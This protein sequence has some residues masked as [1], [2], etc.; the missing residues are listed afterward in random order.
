MTELTEKDGFQLDI[1]YA[2]TNNFTEEQIYKTGRC[3]LHNQM[4]ARIKKANEFFKDKGYGI[5]LFDCYRPR[6]AQ[7]RLWNAF[8]DPNYVGSPLNGS[9]HNR[10]CAVDLSLYETSTGKEVDMG[11]E[12]DYFGQ[13]GWSDYPHLPAQILENRKLLQEGLR[14]VG[15]ETIP[16]EW[17][18]FNFR[19]PG[20]APLQ[21][22]EWD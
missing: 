4:A 22:W 17:W 15:L 3:F 10:G 9:F 2:T 5:K 20:G 18:H 12:F 11:T 8:P 7:L 19:L 13:K 1:R 21:S 14:S 16:R 6:P